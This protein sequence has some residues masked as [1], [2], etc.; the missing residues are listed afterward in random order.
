MASTEQQSSLTKQVILDYKK[1]ELTPKL[2]AVQA[3]VNAA[4]TKTKS[5][6]S[7][8]QYKIC[9]YVKGQEVLNFYNTLDFCEAIS[10]VATSGQIGDKIKKLDA[11]NG[12]LKKQFDD[13]VKAVKDLRAKLSEVETKAY[14]AGDAFEDPSNRDQINALDRMITVNDMNALVDM[15]DKAH[16]Q[17]N[18]AF[19]TAVDVAGILT[20][21]NTESL[22]GFGD[23]LSQKTADFKKNIDENV[24]KTTEDVKK[25]QQELSEASKSLM[26]NKLTAKDP[27]VDCTGLNKTDA[28]LGEGDKAACDCLDPATIAEVWATLEKNYEEPERD[29]ARAVKAAS[30]KDNGRKGKPTL[31]D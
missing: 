27:S 22:K 3:E 14:E 28:F 5:S 21:A 20:F 29:N 25:S 11:K 15:A 16:D 23:A 31:R 1:N 6:E 18:G 26:V 24:K 8:R 17:S 4:Q 2:N 13:V 30:K 7:N 19:S 10:A 12:E 9:A